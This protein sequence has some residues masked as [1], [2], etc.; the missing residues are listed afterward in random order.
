MP[1]ATAA[2]TTEPPSR[3]MG[4]SLDM[5]AVKR[6]AV[7]AGM[8]SGTNTLAGTLDWK[9]F[10]PGVVFGIVLG[11]VLHLLPAEPRVGDSRRGRV[12]IRGICGFVGGAWS[13]L[14]LAYVASGYAEGHAD[15]PTFGDLFPCMVWGAVLGCAWY[16][17]WGFYEMRPGGHRVPG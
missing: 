4:A 8:L 11:M 15:K 17:V 1:E 2:T 13:A 10:V 6:D 3:W 9:W 5:R 12:I 16:V 7:L 14:G